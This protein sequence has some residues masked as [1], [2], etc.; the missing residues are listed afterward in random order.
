MPKRAS[1]PE[2]SG[3][4]PEGK[5]FRL[6]REWGATPKRKWRVCHLI[7]ED[8]DGE[9]GAAL[10]AD[11]TGVIFNL[12]VERE[13]QQEL[14]PGDVELV[15]AVMR[16]VAGWTSYALDHAGRVTRPRLTSKQK[17]A[18]M[19]RDGDCCVVCGKS[20]PGVRLDVHHYVEGLHEEANLVTLC[21]NCHRLV[22]G[23]AAKRLSVTRGDFDD[24][25]VYSRLRRIAKKTVPRSQSQRTRAARRLLSDDERQVRRL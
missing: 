16:K 25:G 22:E 13:D 19:R 21:A 24:L 10:I 2:H 8:E 18:V 6:A 1:E 7:I 12:L 14:E 11:G 4:T 15:L 5:Q 9:T 3:T 23:L 20:S 17:A